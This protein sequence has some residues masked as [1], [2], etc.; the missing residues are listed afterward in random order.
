MESKEKMIEGIREET[1]RNA[2]MLLSA[3]KT[4]DVR[5]LTLLWS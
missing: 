1:L 4:R 2:N 3:A 5:L